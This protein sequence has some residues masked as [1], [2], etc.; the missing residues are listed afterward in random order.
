MGAAEVLSPFE[1]VAVISILTLLL[2][3][4]ISI[5]FDTCCIETIINPTLQVVAERFP[6]TMFCKLLFRYGLKKMIVRI[7]ERN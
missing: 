3:I 2:E 6:V 1:S 7:S 4:F 5:K